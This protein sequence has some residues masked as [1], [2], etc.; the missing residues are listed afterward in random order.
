MRI[1]FCSRDRLERHARV[2]R[3]VRLRLRRRTTRNQS[4][5]RGQRPGARAR[6]RPARIR[7]C[8]RRR[9]RSMLRHCRPSGL[10]GLEDREHRICERVRRSGASRSARAGG[11]GQ[12]PIGTG[13]AAAWDAA[14]SGL[15]GR[16]PA[17]TVFGGLASW[18]RGWSSRR[19]SN[20]TRN[21]PTDRGASPSWCFDNAVSFEVLRRADSVARPP[22]IGFGTVAARLDRS[23]AVPKRSTPRLSSRSSNA[24][25]PKAGTTAPSA[26]SRSAASPCSTSPSASPIPGR[27][28]RTD[29]VMLWYSSGKP[30]TTV[31]VLQL[32]EQEPPRARRPR[33]RL[34]RRLGQRQGALH[35]PPRPHPHRRLPDVP[36]QVPSTRTSRTRTTIRRIAAH[37]ADWEPG[38]AAAYHPVT[39]WKV[40]GAVVEAV[41]GRPI[42]RYLRDEILAPLGID[43]L[44][45]RASR[46]T[47]QAELGD[48]I[49]PVEW[50]GHRLPGRRRRRR[51]EHGAVPHRPA[52]QR[53]VAHRQGRARRRDARARAR[54]RRVLRVAARVRTDRVLEPRTVEVMGA[55]HRHGL[56]DPLFGSTR[57]W[58]LGVAR[59]LHRRRRPARVRARRDGVVTRARRSRLRPRHGGRVQ[60]AAR[61]D[62][63]RATTVEV[64][65]AVYT[66]LGDE[67]ARFRRTDRP[68]DR[69]PCST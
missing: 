6:L 43:R 62:R 59:R 64:T 9:R 35:A 52:A 17:S 19:P 45:A 23:E 29:D 10:D 51:A 49:V 58:G 15:G 7:R 54:A 25:G 4:R 69:S 42:D 39:G 50:T 18:R 44:V 14:G 26:T 61:P 16:R 20:A 53:A 3:V 27:P 36:R 56:R 47:A 60:R 67:R 1:V 8:R 37:P 68:D 12:G 41:D 40:L 46:S 2:G 31:A 11:A 32:W 5:D 38:T 55:V 63:R 21:D 66:A 48:R 33:R 24:S 13:N 57:P 65:D 34:H 30:L 22:P 28:L